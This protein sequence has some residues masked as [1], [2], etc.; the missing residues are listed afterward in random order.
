M[1]DVPDAF[2][3]DDADVFIEEICAYFGVK[4]TN[5]KPIHSIGYEFE[6]GHS[7]IRVGVHGTPAE[8]CARLPNLRAPWVRVHSVDELRRQSEEETE[9]ETAITAS[10]SAVAHTSSVSAT[11]EEPTPIDETNSTVDSVSDAHEYTPS[12]RSDTTSSVSTTPTASMDTVSSVGSSTE[13]KVP[14]PAEDT[15]PP[16]PDRDWTEAVCAMAREGPFTIPILSGK[17]PYRG[18]PEGLR[19]A[20]NNNRQLDWW[21]SADRMRVYC[22]F[23]AGCEVKQETAGHGRREVLSVLLAR[24]RFVVFLSHNGDIVTD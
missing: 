17:G 23:P 20:M 14:R 3:T 7:V 9:A 6:S 8:A 19:D 2:I 18:L 11:A 13:Q 1:T 16:V 5:G 12:D 4:D 24:R 21:I 15:I 22:T 10:V